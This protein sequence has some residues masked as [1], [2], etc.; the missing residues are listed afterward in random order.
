M[1]GGVVSARA[2]VRGEPQ[3]GA[4]G[5]G[6]DQGGGPGVGAAEHN[7]HVGPFEGPAGDGAQRREADRVP[8]AQAGD[9]EQQD[10]GLVGQAQPDGL[11]QRVAGDLVE[12]AAD[13]QRGDRKPP[14]RPAH[15]LTRHPA[16]FMTPDLPSQR[17]RWIG[18]T[19]ALRPGGR[20]QPL[21]KMKY[22]CAPWVCRSE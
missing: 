18:D 7:R 2:E 21:S 8:Y 5:H 20:D 16:S 14:L 15:E 11:L 10:G 12:G 9:I 6:G 1:R 13:V 4:V 19:N 17:A 3:G 22:R